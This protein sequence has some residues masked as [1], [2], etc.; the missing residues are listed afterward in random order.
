[1]ATELLVAKGD[2][3]D[4]GIHW[5][6]Q[7]LS[8]HPE[9]KTKFV[10]GLDKER[11]EAQ[12]PEI[13]RH[14]FDLYKDTV[15]KYNIKP[16]NQ[17]NMDEKGVMMGFIGK[18]KVI[19]SKYEKKGYMTQPGNREWVSL[20]ECI[21]LDGR[22][23]R[24]WVIFKA[25]QHQKAWFSA[26]PGV[27]IATSPNGWTDNE[28]GLEWL[29]VCF[30]PETRCGND[31]YRLL[32]LDGHASHITTAAI[33]FCIASKIIPLCLPP[34]TTH[35]L[36]PLDVGIFLPLATAYKAGV[37]KRS[38]YIVNC[39][40]DKIDF[41][42]IY[43]AARDKAITPIN[44]EKAWKVA[45]LEPWDPEAI[46]SQLPPLPSI[47]PVTPPPS[48]VSL[49]IGP[50]G[51]TVQVAIT[52]ANV[53]QVNHLFDWIVEGE[54]L[55]PITLQKLQKLRNAA[56]L[57]LADRDLQR[58]E[59]IDLIFAENA[60]KKR[61]N[62]EKGKQYAYGRVLNEETIQERE[63]FC[64]FRDYWQGLSRIQPNLLGKP[65]KKPV[66]KASNKL[67]LLDLQLSPSSFRLIS[68]EKLK[69]PGRK[70]VVGRKAPVQRK[71]VQV[72]DIGPIEPVVQTRSGRNVVKTKP[73]EAREN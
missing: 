1:M 39:S 25:K 23:T 37:R 3:Q 61:S 2:I 4:L 32:L 14:W 24:P 33:K 50:T 19:L 43:G 10:S 48:T 62:R 56:S 30:E 67:D 28:I 31:E 63:A 27:H 26:L 34:H 42:E 53:A 6:D 20:I 70:L 65:S 60:K 57:A 40:I 36:Q 52:P 29:K 72:V 38:K 59:N 58:A 44:I 15:R 35:L 73:F 64:I 47:R 71:R 18:V 5:T 21:S 68:P 69:T 9:L 11:A 46:L 49:T 13:F 54:N 17:H 45:G 12:D 22:R 16:R 55:D 51:E 8:R 66:K 41:L 7:F